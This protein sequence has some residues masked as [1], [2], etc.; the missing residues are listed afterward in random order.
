VDPVLLIGGVTAQT[1]IRNAGVDTSSPHRP[2]R[3]LHRLT[4]VMVARAALNLT[5]EGTNQ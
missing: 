1:L 3:L 4:Q 2:N 5:G